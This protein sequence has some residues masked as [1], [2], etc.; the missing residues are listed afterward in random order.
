MLAEAVDDG[1]QGDTLRRPGINLVRNLVRED[2]VDLVLATERDRVARKRGYVFLLEEELREHG[3][4][5]LTLEDTDEDSAEQRLM[6]AIKD[7]FA[8]YEHAK[9]AE[10]T[11]SKK[12]EKARGGEV[13]AGRTPNYGFRYNE[14][15]NGY[16]VD[17]VKMALVRRAFEMIGAEGQTS[18]AVVRWLEGA[19]PH[20][21]TGKGWN[22][23]F[24]RKMVL[25]DVYKSHPY[26]EARVLVPPEAAWR[27]TPDERYGIWWFN[28]TRFE[29]KRTP[30]E[31][32][33]DFKRKYKP[34]G[35]PR[36]EW[37]AVPVPDPGIPPEIV[38]AARERMGKNRAPSENGN[39]FWELSGGIV[40]CEACGYVMGTTSSGTP[41]NDYYYRCRSK[42][43]VKS[44]CDN[45]RGV[46]A[47]AL[48]GEMWEAVSSVLG[49]PARL[50]AGLEGMIESERRT[51]ASSPEK[52]ISRW[53]ERVEKARAM[54]SSYQD[55]QAEG[56]MT[57]EE[58]RVKLAELDGVVR[59]AEA[60]IEKLWRRGGAHPGVGEERR[61]A[62]RR[63]H[64]TPARET[65]GDLP[66]GEEPPLPVAADRGF[67]TQRRRDQDQAA[68]RA[69]EGGVLSA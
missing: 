41:T 62:T 13:I 33:G 5:L 42:Y 24:M 59:T 55:Q 39:R 45:G 40:R 46:R 6:R 15:R 67:G 1:F 9:I 14:G 60:E 7:E 18:Y 32:P 51:L 64:R 11:F 22:L 25:N 38:E 23:P 20:G 21:P 50:R 44:G 27:L 17:E 8:E 34:V 4:T 28:R 53:S 49:H 19:D 52:E 65:A 54:R 58:L 2:R 47:D 63:L 37:I 36:E 16:L 12:L 48:E 66:A 26:E 35:K 31:D 29:P 57:R 69:R 56:L 43:N 3:C 68:L 10:R 61:R 30:P